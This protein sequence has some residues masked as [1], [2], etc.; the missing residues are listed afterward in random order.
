MP[1]IIYYIHGQALTPVGGPMVLGVRENNF[2]R[3]V[4]G[5]LILWGC[6][7]CQSIGSGPIGQ[8]SFFSYLRRSASVILWDPLGGC[9]YQPPIA[10]G[11]AGVNPLTPSA[12]LCLLEKYMRAINYFANYLIFNYI[13][14]N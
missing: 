8:T 5:N 10:S 11:Q 3:L 6:R 4:T 12:H 1:E 9:G 7:G 14:F 13:L 2:G